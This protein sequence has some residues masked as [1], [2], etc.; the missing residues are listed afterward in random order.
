MPS[1]DTDTQATVV[2]SLAPAERQLVEAELK[3]IAR[4]DQQVKTLGA[5]REKILA[6]LRRIA[7]VVAPNEGEQLD[8]D[9]MAV[10]KAGAA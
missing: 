7:G 6:R 5:E 2:R 9:R 10:T 3:D 4:I 1:D 8:L